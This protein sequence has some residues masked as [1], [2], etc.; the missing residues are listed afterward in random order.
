M[1]FNCF[2]KQNHTNTRGRPHTHAHTH[3]RTHAYVCTRTRARTYTHARAHTHTHTNER[4]EERKQQLQK[5]FRPPKALWGYTPPH[6]HTHIHTH[7]ELTVFL[8][9]RCHNYVQNV[10][11]RRLRCSL[12]T[13]IAA[14]MQLLVSLWHAWSVTEISLSSDGTGICALSLSLSYVT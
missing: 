9:G 11:R 1:D 8:E 4:K 6:T 7:T 12:S 2:E 14:E 10:A 5:L 13:I 3:G